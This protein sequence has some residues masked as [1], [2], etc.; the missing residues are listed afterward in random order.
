MPNIIIGQLIINNNRSP[1][2]LSQGLQ[3]SSFHQIY[4]WEVQIQNKMD[5]AFIR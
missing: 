3:K 2:N 5:F 1:I 4:N